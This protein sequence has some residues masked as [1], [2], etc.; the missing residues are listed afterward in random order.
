MT[1]VQ[2]KDLPN[3]QLHEPKG[4][5]TAV[6]KTVYVSAGTGTGTWRK[7]NELDF[8]YSDKAKNLKGWND[9]ADSLYTSA[10]PRAILSGVRTQLTN[11][12]LKSQTDTTRLGT[13]WNTTTNLF[14]INDLNAVYEIR[15]GF[16]ATAVAAAGTP[17]I[18]AIELE[19]ASGP[20]TIHGV[21][22]PLKGGSAVNMVAET[23]FF[24][25]GSFINN[26]NLKI[27]VTPDTAISLYDVGYVIRRA[28]KE[29]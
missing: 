7:V 22:K 29:T 1:I 25:S 10:S 17:Y 2:H 19:S 28:Y 18:I 3:A 23:T 8:D 27:F 14:L 16:K 9:I 24:Y 6:I 5:N 12:G 26:Q 13:I 21:T 4:V 20:T 15:I 11:N